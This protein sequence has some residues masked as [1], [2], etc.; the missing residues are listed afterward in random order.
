[1]PS[2]F[3]LTFDDALEEAAVNA[4]IEGQR[5][6]KLELIHHGGELTVASG[7]HRFENGRELADLMERLQRGTL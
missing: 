2:G 7:T 6:V 1:M 4:A 5:E 3:S